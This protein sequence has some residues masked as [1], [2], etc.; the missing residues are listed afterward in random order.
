MSVLSDYQENLFAASLRT[1]GIYIAL[2]NGNPGEDGTGGTEKTT[3]IKGS[4]TRPSVTWSAVGDVDG[5][6]GFSNSGEFTWEASAQN[7]SSETVDYIAAYDA[8]TGGNMLWYKALD[9]SKTIDNT[10]EV[11][12]ADGA[13]EFVVK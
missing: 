5:G 11:K 4:A 13:I 6:K 2:F 1:S 8:A 10:D 7:V 9:A 3:A 12:F